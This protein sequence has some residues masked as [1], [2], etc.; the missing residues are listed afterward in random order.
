MNT[1]I[2]G[3]VSRDEYFFTKVLKIYTVFFEWALMVFKIWS[4]LLW[5]KFQLKFLVTPMKPLT[6]CEIPYSN[7]LQRAYSGF[8]IVIAAWVSKS[9]S[10]TCLWSWILFRRLWMYTGKN[11]PM[12]AKESRSKNLIRLSEQFWESASFFKEASKN[13]I[14]I[15]LLNK[16][17]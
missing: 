7:P 6:Y 15:F 14:L 2:K 16:T 11:W 1:W 3:I 17:S 9:C 5:R 12:R 8:L 13:F 4:C 10:V